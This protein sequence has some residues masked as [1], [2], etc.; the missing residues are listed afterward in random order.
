M[1]T[2]EKKHFFAFSEPPTNA[3]EKSTEKTADA[4][5]TESNSS[6]QILKKN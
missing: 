1:L 5:K 4:N 2:W 6:N 3:T